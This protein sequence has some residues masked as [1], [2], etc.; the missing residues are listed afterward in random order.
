MAIKI[1]SFVLRI[2]GLLALILGVLFW[3]GNAAQLIPLHMLLGFLVVLSLWVIGIGQALVS[4]GSPV[5]AVLAVVIGLLLPIIGLMQNSWLLNSS[6][7][8]IQVVHLLIAV[9]AIGLGEMG[10]ARYRR[11]SAGV[12]AS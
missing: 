1:A 11:A 12:S 2:A 5:I 7:W 6:H 3:T 9:L 10:A 8:I 4:G